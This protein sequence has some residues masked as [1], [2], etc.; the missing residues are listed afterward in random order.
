MCWR[1]RQHQ[2]RPI[3]GVATGPASGRLLERRF[4]HHRLLLGRVLVL[5]LEL[6]LV[7][8]LVLELVLELVLV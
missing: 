7:L 4:P 5:V 2:P 1:L 8:V 6:V 3:P